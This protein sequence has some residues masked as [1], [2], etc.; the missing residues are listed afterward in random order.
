MKKKLFLRLANVEK[1]EEEENFWAQNL[2]SNLIV[3]FLYIR[4]P[5]P[6]KFRAIHGV[7]EITGI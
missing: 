3:F 2:G 6:G 4:G 5:W 1:D 7:I